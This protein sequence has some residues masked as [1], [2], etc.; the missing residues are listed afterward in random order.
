MAPS[1]VPAEEDAKPP[2]YLQSTHLSRIRHTRTLAGVRDSNREETCLR[3]GPPRGG[4][5]GSI[6]GAE[7]SPSR[8]PSTLCEINSIVDTSNVG[9]T[10]KRASREAKQQK[11]ALALWGP[12]S[13][14]PDD[15][16]R[17]ER[18]KVSADR[19]RVAEERLAVEFHEKKIRE[20]FKRAKVDRALGKGFSHED[21]LQL[22]TRLFSDPEPATSKFA[23]TGLKHQLGLHH[24]SQEREV[25][26]ELLQLAAE[27]LDSEVGDVE[28]S[29]GWARLKSSI[30]TRI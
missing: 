6:G 28:L 17:F 26:D 12:S 7:G 24:T 2:R 5:N 19:A 16:F 25:H 30:H 15:S 10:A 11:V 20:D 18:Q 3:S 27:H 9:S 8:S 23:V 1:Q 29:K 21:L 13:T 4:S 14:S 22:Q